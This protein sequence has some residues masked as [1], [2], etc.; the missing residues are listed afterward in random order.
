MAQVR[1]KEEKIL[2]ENNYVLKKINFDLQKSDGSWDNQDREIYDRGNAVTVLLYNK[3][4]RTVILTR[5]FRLA[6]Y[7]NGNPEGTLIETCAGL[8][9]EGENADETVKREIEEETGYALTDVQKVYEA[10]TSAGVLTER[11]YLYVA[12]YTKEQR[13]G[14]GGG[15]EE[16]G[17]EV[18]VLE[19]PFD[20]AVVMMER[21]EIKDA[22]TIILLQYAKLKQLL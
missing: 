20:E 10:Y 6:T 18:Q 21:G 4:A 13:T 8:L 15:L 12:P 11:L 1:I 7:L 16:E 19:M 22:K 5:Q 17:E 14:K 2:S 3:E 9:E